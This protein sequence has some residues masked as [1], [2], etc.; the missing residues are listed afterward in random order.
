M[1]SGKYDD[2]RQPSDELLTI[3]ANNVRNLRKQ[4]GMTQEALGEK[5]NFNP[6]FIS[7]VERRQRNVTISTLE[8]IASALSV[9]PYD[10]LK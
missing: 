7:L 3:L 2:K 4:Q 9:K 10:L 8:I 1:N 6:T 5:C